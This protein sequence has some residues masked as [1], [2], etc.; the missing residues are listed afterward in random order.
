MVRLRPRNGSDACHSNHDERSLTFSRSLLPL[1]S[2][3]SNL[4]CDPHRSAWVTPRDPSSLGS[5][6]SASAHYHVAAPLDRVPAEGLE[7]RLGVPYTPLQCICGALVGRVWRAQPADP[8]RA[9]AGKVMLD[10][11]ALRD[12]Y[13][14]G[15]GQSFEPGA[16]ATAN[17][18]TS[19][20]DAGSE[21]ADAP[22]HI[23]VLES[24]M[25]MILALR[26]ENLALRADVDAM[27]AWAGGQKQ[28]PTAAGAP[29]LPQVST[30]QVP[31]VQ[32]SAQTPPSHAQSPQQP[33]N[34]Q[35]ARAS[36][37]RPPRAP[38][39]IGGV[40]SSGV[41][42]T[43]STKRKVAPSSSAAPTASPL[44]S[45]SS[46]A[47]SARPRPTSAAKARP[48]AATSL[49]LPIVPSAGWSTSPII[50]PPPPPAAAG[51]ASST[52][53]ALAGAADPRYFEA[54]EEDLDDEELARADEDEEDDELEEEEDDE[55]QLPP[56]KRQR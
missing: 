4:S 34:A 47:A 22:P 32:S 26:E 18:G 13:I 11:A 27:I 3:G 12:S 8:S 33:T 45:P 15:S 52:P 55:D 40:T 31:P 46:S 2:V 49:R 28:P 19:G 1:A 56:K 37:A 29:T 14:V 36:S 17:G 23:T 48:R 21:E 43:P 41:T 24:V 42:H 44:A 25:T 38:A 10:R 51:A 54:E 30:T 6:E 16:G 35:P 39:V 9:F 50:P 7:W 5:H 53:R 20:G